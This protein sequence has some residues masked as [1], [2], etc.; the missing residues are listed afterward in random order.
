MSRK[1]QKKRK[2]LSKKAKK[3]SIKDIKKDTE[4][5]NF[6]KSDVNFYYNLGGFLLIFTSLILLFANFTKSESLLKDFLT[7]K[8]GMSYIPLVFLIFF[9]GISCLRFITIKKLNFH[10]F[11]S[12]LLLI[13]SFAL[14][15]SI[16]FSPSDWLGIY[17]GGYLSSFLGSSLT[18]ILATLLALVSIAMFI[19]LFSPGILLVLLNDFK[20]FLQKLFSSLTKKNTNK[21]TREGDSKKSS[22]KDLK[23]NR[24]SKKNT[25]KKSIKKE[26]K[27]KNKPISTTKNNDSNG[28]NTSNNISSN[29]SI[30]S[31]ILGFK[32]SILKILSSIFKSS[33]STTSTNLKNNEIKSASLS[34]NSKENKNTKSSIL[35][36]QPL[37]DLGKNNRKKLFNSIQDI[38][39]VNYK[40]NKFKTDK[41]F[42][43]ITKKYGPDNLVNLS[44]ITKSNFANKST[45]SILSSDMQKIALINNKA[46]DN[47]FTTPYKKNTPTVNSIPSKKPA[48]I[49]DSN[50]SIIKNTSDAS[51][52]NISNIKPSNIEKDMDKK[53]ININS[54]DALL[55]DTL[56]EV[57][58]L[59]SNVNAVVSPQVVNST[60]NSKP[61]LPFTNK[62][63]NY[64]SLEVLNEPEGGE[65]DVGDI[66]DRKEIITDTLASFSINSEVEEVN[67]GPSVTQYAIS[68]QEGVRL[69]KITGL[70]T[71]I[72]LAVSSPS[73]NV[74]IE[75]PIPGKP[76]VGIEIPNN[77]QEI[78]YLKEMIESNSYKEHKKKSK[79]TICLGKNIKGEPVFYA[80]NKM[81]HLL[82]AGATGSGK[83]IMIHSLITTLLF[84]NSPNECKLILVDPKRVELV[85][86]NDI[87]HLI[88]PVIT[89]TQGAVNSLKWA[90]TEMERR[91]DVLSAANSRD[92]D[93][94]NSKAGF[95]SM[96]YLVIV[97]DELADLMMTSGKE[98]EASIVRIAQLARATGIH[99]VLATQRPST[100]I[101]TGSIK[102]NVPARIAFNVTSNIDSRV[103]IDKPGAETLLGKGDM[104]FMSPDSSVRKRIQG[105]YI[106]EK[107]VEKLVD[108]LKKQGFEPDY[109]H[110]IT[111][112]PAEEESVFKKPKNARSDGNVSSDELLPEAAHIV[113]N[114][115]KG[116]TSLLQRRLSIGYARAARLIDELEDIGVLG[117]SKGSKPREVLATNMEQV[118]NK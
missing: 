8:L 112:Q 11:S 64:P 24:K 53:N 62:V 117:P 20:N 68:V 115:K 19:E 56:A 37:E 77:S 50:T 95:Q 22:S 105:V 44:T 16:S 80:L 110:E 36:N 47:T 109:V 3:V 114:S 39:E 31:L 42:E 45:N 86:Y 70:S 35:N 6:S 78:V 67:I 96:P 65:P 30:T 59:N 82:I 4:A 14:F 72:A 27:A 116:S 103:V 106:S 74:R 100:N 57:N 85:A 99:L 84:N 23:I 7:S 34:K 40:E 76:L 108:K 9:L 92:I 51:I 5:T 81:P 87:P 48:N 98:V 15:D 26:T 113:I 2:D 63:W 38:K 89:D 54:S 71:D 52:T 97:L 25:N 88:T 111:A 73:G 83:S 107:E 79:L 29:F 118:L 49:V 58:S 46:L 10:F 90:V 28:S 61:P 101:I 55:S 94:Y 17:L 13:F 18:S 66:E 75:A 93:T 104:L 43:V 91:L 33:K 60:T 102:A 69:K 32:N 1:A 21:I 12:L 41:K